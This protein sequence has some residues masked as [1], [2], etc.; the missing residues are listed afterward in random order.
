VTQRPELHGPPMYF[1]PDWPSAH[2]SVAK[3][4]ELA[5]QVVVTGHGPAMEGDEMLAA[6]RV[7]A[8]EFDQVAVPTQG[9][10]VHNRRP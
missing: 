5:P 6:L 8:G 7:L 4:A 9:R 1:T 3:L 10:Y 2:A